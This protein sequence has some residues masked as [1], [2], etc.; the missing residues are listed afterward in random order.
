MQGEMGYLAENVAVRERADADGILA[1]AKSV[2]C[3]ARLYQRAAEDEAKD[4]A[5]ARTLARY[6]R[7]QDYHNF[8]KRKLRK[9]AAFVR[10]LGEGVRARA[11]ADDAPILERAWAARSGIGFVGKNGLVIVPGKGSMLLLGEVITTLELPAGTP[12]E[13]RC[14]SCT[15]CLDACPTRAFVRPFVL[16]PRRC[17]SY[18][19]IEHRSAIAEELR[20][21]VG[22]HLFGCD[23]CQAVCPFNR[24]RERA[25]EPRPFEPLARWSTLD[26]AA[27]LA[28]DDEGWPAIAHGS[29]VKRATKDGLARNAAVVLGN[30]GDPSALPALTRAAASH[31]SA[32]VRE[33][34]AWAVK[35]LGG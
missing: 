15:L 32:M 28:V 34:A 21:G 2:I 3:L 16:D 25:R 26:V 7:G 35:R 10:T 22:D 11:L 17:V 23:D 27:L 13:E 1:G 20:A 24:A 33:A 6:A 9:L 19:T 12:M 18:L 5:T 30:R 31:P 8:L 4:P 29:P 14:G